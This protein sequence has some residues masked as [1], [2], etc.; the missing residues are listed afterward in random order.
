M[1]TEDYEKSVTDYEKICQMD[2]SKENVAA[3]KHAKLELKKSKR[4]DYYK[5][6]GVSKD[7]SD[8]DIKKAYRKMALKE[9]P[10]LF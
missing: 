5:I 6:L 2:K 9:H 10:G 7:A 3:L 1:D 4:K 8:D